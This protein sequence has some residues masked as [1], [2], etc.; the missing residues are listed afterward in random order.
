MRF[1][2]LQLQDLNDEQRRILSDIQQGPRGQNNP[3][4]TEAPSGLFG[5]MIRAP[6]LADPGQKVG[7]YLRY[8]SSLEERIS[9]FAIIITA[10]HWNSQRVWAAHCKL[11]LK[12]GLGRQTAE[13]LAQPIS[14]GR[15]PSG[16]K[17]DEAAAFLYCTELHTTR[18][19]SDA[20][21]A[22]TMRQFGEQGI[23]DLT[24]V[25]GYYTMASMMQ[26]INDTA[27]PPGAALPVPE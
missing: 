6:G 16:M 3:G 13:D 24:G 27:L 2:P 21:F 19:V 26:N 8:G 17:E 5:V 22:A 9:E 20:T 4:R 15:Q 12:A 10:R 11:A 18:T 1:K 7:A 25:C 23:V 14:P